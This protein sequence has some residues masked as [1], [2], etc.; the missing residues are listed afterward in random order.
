MKEADLIITNAR[1]YTVDP[2]FS[3]VQGFA[4]KE[5]LILAT[6]SDKEIRNS[7][8]ADTTI[9]LKGKTVYPG[10]IDP[11][12]HFYGYGQS[13][14]NIDL[15]GTK[16]AGEILDKLKAFAGTEESSWLIGQGWDQNDWEENSFPDRSLLDKIFPDRPVILYR[17]DGHA[18]WVNSKALELA[19][20]NA[21]TVAEGGEILQKEGR[22]TGILIDNAVEFI[23][24]KIPAPGPKEITGSLLLAQQRCF[25]VGLTSVHDAGLDAAVIQIIDSLNK[26]NLLNIRIFAMLNPTKEN[27]DTY[28]RKGK[29]KT[30][31]L[32]VS[33]IKL[34][35]DGALGSRGA[36][37]IQPYSDQ[38]STR[39]L[40]ISSNEFIRSMAELADGA[41]YQVCTH[42]IGDGANR[43][44]LQVYARILKGENDKRWRIEHAQIV[45]PDDIHLFG[46]FSI[47]P[48]I[49]TTHAT[50]DM[51]WAAERLGNR[52]GYA[53][54]YRAL[55][56]QN[57]WI[58]NG[59]DFPV[60]SI[61]P[62]LGFYAAFTRQD[63]SGFPPGGFQPSDTLS[64]KEALKA[65]TI[66]AAQSAFEENEKGS[67]EPGKYADFVVTDRDIMQEEPLQVPKV[68]VLSTYVGGNKVY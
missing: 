21:Q 10:F 9:D 62:I 46:E 2:D 29:Y 59:S 48:S 63:T 6:G 19:S 5:G 43:D 41:G 22:P 25:S 24:Q 8:K 14:R 49:Q 12:C 15:N 27:I 36:R 35:A 54:P 20:I 66:W 3:I 31:R 7:F 57:G 32:N 58:P 60:E 65:M 50:S 37:L 13:L 34:Y 67:L 18:A 53:Y 52:I 26:D 11:H 40:F 16:S 33:S 1:V 30:D 47:I 55:L 28:L 4:V 42:C 61:N 44:V 17:V 64:R 56:E 51:Y 38:E 45:H 23:N 68:K 39:G